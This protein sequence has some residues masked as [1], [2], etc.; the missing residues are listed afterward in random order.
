MQHCIAIPLCPDHT[1]SSVFCASVIACNHLVLYLREAASR[2]T[3][4]GP[5]SYSISRPTSDAVF[6]GHDSDHTSYDDQSL[7]NPLRKH[8]APN[9]GLR[10]GTSDELQPSSRPTLQASLEAD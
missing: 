8:N 5:L 4:T 1:I 10:S 9:L 2:P 7:P 3:S 6:I